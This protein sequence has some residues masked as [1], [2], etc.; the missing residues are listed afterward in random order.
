MRNDVTV[1]IFF[2]QLGR[3]TKAGQKILLLS[4]ST[5]VQ[6]FTTLVLLN[7]KRSDEI[8]R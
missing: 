6:L 5:D 8:Y 3:W 4:V 2:Q 1:P 7:F